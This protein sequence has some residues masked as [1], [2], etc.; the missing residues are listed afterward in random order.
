MF[1]F[2]SRSPAFPPL[3]PADPFPLSLSICPFAIP[4]LIFNFIDCP[5][6][7]NIFLL[8]NRHLPA[9]YSFLHCNLLPLVMLFLL[10]FYFC[11]FLANQNHRLQIDFQKIREP[12]AS[13]RITEIAFIRILSL[14]FASVCV[15]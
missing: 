5:L 6:R 11:R 14:T 9:L 2:K 4:G 12:A 3:Y 13:E 7:S 8:L 15:L 10:L 1:I